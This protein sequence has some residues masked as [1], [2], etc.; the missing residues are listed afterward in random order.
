[1][2]FVNDWLV[3]IEFDDQKKTRRLIAVIAACAW[4]RLLHGYRSGKTDAPAMNA[5]ELKGKH[6]WP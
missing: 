5:S 6:P 4:L 1:L 3:V 2:A